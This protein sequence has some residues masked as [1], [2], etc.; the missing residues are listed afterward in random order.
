MKR[1]LL[2]CV[3]LAVAGLP[4]SATTPLLISSDVP[5][6]ETATFT[7][8]L[9]SQVYRYTVPPAYVLTL[10]VPGNP[11]LDA[12]HKMDRFGSWLFSIEAAN[13]LAGALGGVDADPRDVIRF[14]MTAGTYGFFFCGASVGI[15][16]GVNVDAVYLD[17][18]DPGSL[19]V[20]FDVPVGLGPFVFDPADL[21]RYVRTGP[22]CGN[23]ALAAA[24]PDFDASAAGVGI[25]TSVN[26]LDAARVGPLRIFSLD[27][28][29][30]LGPP[31]IVTYLPGQI[32]SWNGAAFA[33]YEA[34]AGWPTSSTVDGLSTVGNPGVVA[35]TLTMN[36]TASPQ[37][38]TSDV[39]LSWG[40]S[41]SE[42]ASD[43]GIY[44]G[45]IGS[46]YGHT[47]LDCFDNGVLLTEQVTPGA[48]NRY[49]LVVP[50]NTQTE[51]SYGQR[52]DNTPLTFTERP[53]GA[54]QC[55][56]AQAI[57]ACP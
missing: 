1:P 10:T 56:A 25:P 32:V 23:W 40:A 5:T 43:Y 39:I 28:P 29:A 16:A 36:K 53:V 49:Y 11:R 52:R 38:D 30:D 8:L 13:N 54:A 31:G 17:G 24:N 7:T 55:I 15:P 34:L 4:A 21:V 3:A 27:V 22:A 35:A 18:G 14:D 48:G 26:M 45:T 42:G 57:T 2:L 47:S 9:S 20:S 19:I 44:Q 46:W 50:H 51:G 37:L 41:C 33:L 12:I 6:T